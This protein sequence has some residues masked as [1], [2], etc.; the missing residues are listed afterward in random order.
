MLG[1]IFNIGGSALNAQLV[2]M[3]VASS[4]L[5]NINTVSTNEDDAYRAK[6]V[7]FKAIMK[8]FSSINDS[9]ALGQ[10][11]GGVNISKISEDKTPVKKQYDPGNPLADKEGYIYQS[12]VSEVGEMVE[13]MAAARTY[14]NNVETLNTAKQL[15]L[16]TIDLLRS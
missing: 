15:M 11:E 16:R 1:K 6:R 10:N 4:N 7:V 9:M 14:Q 3:N 12:N 5:A 8:D 2:R 13:M